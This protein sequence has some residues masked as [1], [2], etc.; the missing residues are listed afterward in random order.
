[1]SNEEK[2]PTEH[3]SRRDIFLS[4]GSLLAA[5]AIS[6]IAVQDEAVRKAQLGHSN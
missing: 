2:K 6:G 3:L 5:A 1:M 4:G